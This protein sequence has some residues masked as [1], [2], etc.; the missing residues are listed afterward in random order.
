M[1]FHKIL[2][3]FTGR[4]TRVGLGILEL[5]VVYVIVIII[6]ISLSSP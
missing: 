5:I 2:P 3:V 4:Y 6:I 1:I